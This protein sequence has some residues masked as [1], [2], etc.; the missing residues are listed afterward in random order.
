MRTATLPTA[1]KTFAQPISSAKLTAEQKA[2]RLLQRTLIVLVVL[3]TFEGLGRKL[4]SGAIGILIFL[5]KDV[6]VLFMGLQL[7]LRHKLPPAIGF[8]TYAYMALV[9][10]LLPNIINT[11]L[12]DP[13]LALFG[14]KE[15]L[16]YPIVAI[17][18]FAAFRNATMHEI[19]RF[20][21]FVAFLM[22]PTGL[23][24]MIQ[25][26]LPASHWLNLSVEGTSL[27]NFSS[28]GHL[29]V[30]STFSFVSQYC[31]FLNMQMFMV[32]FA[33]YGFTRVK[34]RV[35]QLIILTS[36]PC[37]IVSCFLTGSRGAVIG[38]MSVLVFAMMLGGLRGEFG[39]VMRF[40]VIAGVIVCVALVFQ[41]FFPSLMATYSKREQGHVFG[42]SD[43]IQTRVYNAFFGWMS[44]TQTVPFFGNGLGIMSNGSD[45]ISPYSKTF[46]LEGWTETDF[47]TTLFE[48]GPYLIVVWYAFRFYII[49]ETTRRF[50]LQTSRQLFLPGA[51]CQGYVI[52]VGMTGTIAIQP[53]IAIWWYL[54]VGLSV[55]LWW[56]SVH[57]I[58]PISSD[59]GS[60]RPPGES[61]PPA[62]KM[63]RGRSSYADRLHQ[64][65]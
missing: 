23:V 52:L 53:P 26:Q 21:R 4:E 61:A 42:V 31:C 65:R 36:V 47:A 1:V 35:G 5:F 63:M 14:A 39:K 19:V 49:F 7:V 34:S 3:L 41:A 43:E 64:R 17:S 54:G 48:G 28:A 44:D 33:F 9:F 62:P 50:L 16:L 11:G 58:E 24:A 10:F 56:R 46:R 59:S 27:E 18:V 8:I 37:M 6:V 30:S 2:I 29:R 22:I 12:H 60:P 55:I 51:F 25:T 13:L 20:C 40:A 38:N 57:P 32:F 15:Y 45:A